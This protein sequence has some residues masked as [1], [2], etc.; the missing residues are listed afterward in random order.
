MISFDSRKFIFV[1]IPK[2]AGTGIRAA[3]RYFLTA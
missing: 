1:H 3:L 2:K